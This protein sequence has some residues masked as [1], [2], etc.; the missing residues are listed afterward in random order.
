MNVCE[1]G[2]WLFPDGILGASPEGLVMD[3][4]P[5]N[6]VIG[7]LEVRCP[8]RLHEDPIK[9]DVDWHK[10]IPN[11][12]RENKL[13]KKSP[14]YQQCQGHLMATGLPWCDFIIWSP[15]HTLIERIYPDQ[16]CFNETSLDL[17]EYYH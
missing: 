16:E 11:I 6:E 1:T 5:P 8:H 13:V 2:I 3:P 17:L 12:D 7:C 15:S 14:Y 9:S 4:N 10:F